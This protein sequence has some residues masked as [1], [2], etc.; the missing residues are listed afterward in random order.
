MPPGI[1][2]TAGVAGRT[3][4]PSTIPRVPM[5]VDPPSHLRGDWTMLRW[6]GWILPILLLAIGTALPLYG[7]KVGYMSSDMIRSK[8]EPSRQAEERLNA[9]V[10]EWK[11]ELATKQK[12]IEE[13]E[14]EIRK[15]RLIWT[16]A[17]RQ[18]KE[19]LVEEK[20]RQ[21]DA[22]AR[23][24]FEVGGEHDRKAEEYLKGILTKIY[25]AAQKVAAA[26]GYDIVFDKS[27]D[28]L[29]Y[30]NAKYDLTLKVMK[31][32]GIEAADLE[33]KQQDVI[34]ADPRN[35][36]VEE[37]RRRKSRTTKPEEPAQAVTPTRRP[38]DA[39][40]QPLPTV[41][42]DSTDVLRTDEEVPR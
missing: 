11:Q 9:M 37:P 7:Q 2:G 14:L 33:R 24:K 3:D 38:A 36:R 8:Y 22:F 40:A 32:L 35:K 25:A 17:E 10:M 15:N 39:Q 21:R 34:N 5:L 31:E 1:Q 30:V 26:E 23:E 20:R 18:E 12:D 19:R 42:V 13:F 6:S 41:P 28:P 16:D 29:V 27:R 4:H